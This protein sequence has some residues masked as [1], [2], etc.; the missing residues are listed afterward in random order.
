MGVI[1]GTDGVRGT[2][3]RELSPELAFKLGRA[4]AHVL[5]RRVP[6][7]RVVIGRDT[8]VSGDMLEA[9]LVSGI[10]SAGADVLKI[11]VLPTP[12]VAF[13]TRDLN[14]AA[15]VVI[16]ASHNPFDDNGIKFFGENGRKLSD[17]MEAEIE[18]L[19]V[20]DCAGVPFPGGA[21]VGRTYDVQDA[22]DRYVNFLKKAVDG[23]F[24]G[25]K[26]VVDCANGAASQVA[27]RVLAELG[28]EVTAIFDRPDGLNINEGCGSTHTAG[29]QEKVVSLGADLGLAHD[30]DADRLLAVDAEGRLV[31]GDQIMVAIAR[32]LQER[33]LLAQNTVVVTVMS[34]LG[35]HLALKESGIK[36][37]E[38]RVGDRYVLEE[39]IR[40]GAN[41]GGEQSGHI[42]FLDHNTTG[43]GILTA[44]MLLSVVKRSG[45]TLA[46]LAA[47]MERFPQ[48]LENVRVKDKELVM[49][50]PLLQAAVREQ[51]ERLAGRGR[52]LVRPSGTEPLVR[53]M[54]EGQDMDLLRDVVKKLVDVTLAI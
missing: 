22:A 51:E 25:L 6:H 42:L 5:A 39:L 27:P 23:N 28:A 26:V 3:N 13:L 24:D 8:R 12:A 11:G 49:H 52:I 41:F 29:L 17:E 10:C 53:V 48:L 9:A 32:D 7:A 38:T 46:E 18:A 45:R 43:D 40:G 34:N 37:A 50:S 2:A 47:Q 20:D 4:G 36:V 16:S 35:L 30:G 1:F 44:L 15:G 14:A 54:A 33:N 19:V 21:G 31:D